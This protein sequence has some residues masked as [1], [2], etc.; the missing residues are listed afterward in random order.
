MSEFERELQYVKQ[1]YKKV[2][3]ADDLG[4]AKRLKQLFLDKYVVKVSQTD[5]T[6]LKIQNELHELDVETTKRITSLYRF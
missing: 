4:S 6:F 2:I 5:K 1:T 3:T